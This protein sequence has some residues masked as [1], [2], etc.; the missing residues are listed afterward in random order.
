MKHQ[1]YSRA[2][3]VCPRCNN[4]NSEIIKVGQYEYARKCDHS[5]RPT[6]PLEKS[7]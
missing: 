1:R 7:K 3:E 5:T 2:K 6:L 4:T